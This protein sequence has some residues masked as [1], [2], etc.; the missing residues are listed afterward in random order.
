[1]TTVG[2]GDVTPATGLGRLI[3]TLMMLMHRRTLAVPTGIVT[4][5]MS[6]ARG[7]KL[8]ITTR[9]CANCMTEGHLPD[10]NYCM[11]CGEQLMPVEAVTSH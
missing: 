9:T 2:Y 1:M 10:A 3:P 11:H 8:E 5:E 4:V 6:N 7:K